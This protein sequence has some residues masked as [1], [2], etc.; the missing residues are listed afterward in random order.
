M[1]GSHCSKQGQALDFSPGRGGRQVLV[2]APL[3]HAGSCVLGVI[4]SCQPTMP[5]I[6]LISPWIQHCLVPGQAVCRALGEAKGSC[7]SPG[8]GTRPQEGMEPKAFSVFQSVLVSISVMLK[9]AYLISQDVCTFSP[10]AKC[11]WCSHPS[12]GLQALILQHFCRRSLLQHWR[13]SSLLFRYHFTTPIRATGW[14][15]SWCAQMG[16]KT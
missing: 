11:L 9:W 16:R 4:T 8:F 10:A 1:E 14:K 15:C 7:S 3:L 13:W 6:S 5:S 2:A 12:Q